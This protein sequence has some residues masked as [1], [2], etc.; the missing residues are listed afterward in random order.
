M[1]YGDYHILQWVT[2]WA[3]HLLEFDIYS[4]G[5]VGGAC[6]GPVE[7]QLGRDLEAKAALHTNQPTPAS[8]HIETLAP[9][10]AG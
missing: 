9:L 6:L 3:S 7:P 10:E 8:A 1:A 5:K 2:Y 4:D